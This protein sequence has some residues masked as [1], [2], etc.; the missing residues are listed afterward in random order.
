MSRYHRLIAIFIGLCVM[1]EGF[2]ASPYSGTLQGAGQG[3]TSPTKP[4]PPKPP[5]EQKA[6]PMKPRTP[7][8]AQPPYTHPGILV[9]K[10]DVWKGYDYLFNLTKEIGVTVEIIKPAALKIGLSE[11]KLKSLVIEEFRKGG[12]TPTARNAEDEPSLPFLHIQVLIYPVDSGYAVACEARLFEAV[13][14]KRVNLDRGSSIQAITWEKQTLLVTPTNDLNA[15]TEK[16]VTDMAND[17]VQLFQL[18]E[19]MKK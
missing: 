3:V 4:P 19:T 8:A 1:G 14:V 9:F 17:F 6:P 5:V 16:A 11:E 2:S 10:D 18:Y 13:S 7:P 12:I 15:S